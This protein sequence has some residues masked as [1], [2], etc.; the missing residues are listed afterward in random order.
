MN[1]LDSLVGIFRIY[2]LYLY[3]LIAK[4]FD[5]YELSVLAEL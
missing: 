4:E 1:L 2:D 3:W 5:Y